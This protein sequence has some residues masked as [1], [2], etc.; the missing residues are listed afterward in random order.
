M[1]ETI[2]EARLKKL[3]KT[4]V[5]EVLEE[6]SDLVSDAVAAA[7]EDLAMVRAIREGSHSGD[8]SRDEVFKTLRTRR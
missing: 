1:I 5:V 2:D 6:R 7:V 3:L 4:A 8:I